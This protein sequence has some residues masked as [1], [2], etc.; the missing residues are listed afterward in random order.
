M[1]PDRFNALAEQ[2]IK[3]E[4]D[5]FAHLAVA[6]LLRKQHRAIVRLVKAIE[7]DVRKVKKIVGNGDVHAQGMLDGVQCV[8]A[9]L[10]R[11]MK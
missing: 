10:D 4:D 9:A 8:L 5:C 2:V 6:A 3:H 1:K 7:Q 11:R